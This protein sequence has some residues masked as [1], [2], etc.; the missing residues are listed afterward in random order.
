MTTPIVA[1]CLV[2]IKSPAPKRSL[3]WISPLARRQDK[4]PASVRAWGTVNGLD[5]SY[6][7]K[8]KAQCTLS[9]R[10]P[11]EGQ[12]SFTKL[13]IR[14]KLTNSLRAGTDSIIYMRFGDKPLIK[15]FDRPSANDVVQHDVDV[16][17]IFGSKQPAMAEL[18]RFTLLQVVVPTVD[19]ILGSTDQWELER[20]AFEVQ[21]SPSTV[22]LI[23][24]QHNAINTWLGENAKDTD[25]PRP[26]WSAELKTEAWRAHVQ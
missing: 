8:D 16:A 19:T 10:G 25:F 7:A 23:N 11:K 2:S 6:N 26:V 24:D 15:L 22:T 20:L 9:P 18:A 5:C 4:C 12:S 3:D 14:A 17:Q 1:G 13:Q 21:H